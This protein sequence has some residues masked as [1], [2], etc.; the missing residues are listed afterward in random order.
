MSLRLNVN[1]EDR[2]SAAEPLT[3]LVDV[4]R[5]EFHLTGAKIVCREGFCG[6]CTVLLDGRPVMSCL[7]PV[8]LAAD[9]E[10]RTVESLATHGILSPL[11]Q[12]MEE[13]DAVQCGMCFPGMLMSLSSFLERVPNPSRDDIRAA[14]A[15]N[16]C[17]CTGYERIVDAALSVVRAA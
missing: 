2:Y 6:A 14:L 1:G 13:H 17:R 4:L 15:G 8:G 3:P 9:C 10:V 16:I 12:A 7:V 5:D 11:Q